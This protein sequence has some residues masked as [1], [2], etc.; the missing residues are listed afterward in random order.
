MTHSCRFAYSST[1]GHA[2]GI[3]SCCLFRLSTCIELGDWPAMFE[4]LTEHLHLKIL[5]ENP[6]RQ[7]SLEKITHGFWESSATFSQ[8][9]PKWANSSSTPDAC[10]MVL[11]YANLHEWVIFKGFLCRFAY[12]STMVRIWLAYFLEVSIAIL[13]GSTNPKRNPRRLNP[14]ESPHVFFAAK[15]G[16]SSIP[17]KNKLMFS[18]WMYITI[19]SMYGIYANKTGVYWW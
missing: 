5:W 11:E 15:H 14:H 2:S 3:G 12:S 6:S 13:D 1:M 8:G 4:Q 10:P 17:A 9:V 18:W 19:G 7:I 16:E